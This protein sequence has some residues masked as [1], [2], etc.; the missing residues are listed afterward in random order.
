MLVWKIFVVLFF[1]FMRD[2][3]FFVD[4][5]FLLIK[6]SLV[7]CWVKSRDVVC[8]FFKVL[9]GVCLVLMMIV[10]LF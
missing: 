4:V 2:V 3:V 1:D 5:L 9:L 8:L 6:R 10:I 7:F